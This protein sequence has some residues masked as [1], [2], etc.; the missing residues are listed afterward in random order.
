MK[1]S[2]Q[3]LVLSAAVAVGAGAGVSV[4][5]ADH[6]NVNNVPNGWTSTKS[7]GKTICFNGCSDNPVACDAPGKHGT[8]QTGGSITYHPKGA[9]GLNNPHVFTVQLKNGPK[10]G[11]NGKPCQQNPQNP[12][13]PK[14]NK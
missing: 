4:A 1:L 12:D 14:K 6:F 3:A 2:K 13:N 5:L 11:P 9:G 7:E 10:L 8:Q